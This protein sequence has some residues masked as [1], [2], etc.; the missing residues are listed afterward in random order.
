[1]TNTWYWQLGT[2]QGAKTPL[3]PLQ[4]I[5]AS[6]LQGQT[7][8]YCRSGLIY[9]RPTAYVQE[10]YTDSN[11]HYPNFGQS[12]VWYFVQYLIWQREPC[13]GIRINNMR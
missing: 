11:L 4:E 3:E 1:M 7:S 10:L 8:Q 5:P 12:T 2:I 9:T 13:L 6:H